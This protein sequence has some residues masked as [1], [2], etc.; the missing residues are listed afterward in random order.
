VHRL[1]AESAADRVDAAQH[2]LAAESLA[3]ESGTAEQARRELEEAAQRQREA[4]ERDERVRERLL[5]REQEQRRGL[6]RFL[7]GPGTTFYSPGMFGTASRWTT[8]E[9]IALDREVD[10]IARALSE[11]GPT[12]RARLAELV[13]GRYWGPGR[14][15]AA[16]R[17]AMHEGRAQPLTGNRYGPSTPAEPNG[18]S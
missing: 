6:R 5:R 9:D 3:E 18:E 15:R 2:R 1:R 16:L 14:F 13:G 17:E 8:G 10:A 12:D 7:P 4:R 11:H